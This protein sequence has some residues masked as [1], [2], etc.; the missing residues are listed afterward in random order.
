MPPAVPSPAPG[1]APGTPLTP[2]QVEKTRRAAQDFEAMALNQLLAPM[3]ETV[4]T[5]RGPF[6]GGE[7]EQ[8]WKP[9]MVQEMAKAVARAG[10]LGLA[11][12]VMEQMLRMQEAQ[13]AQTGGARHGG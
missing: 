4:D 3:F 5:S 11:K 13:R 6:G 10:G 1:T 12:P 9:M 2:Q 8:A 7:G